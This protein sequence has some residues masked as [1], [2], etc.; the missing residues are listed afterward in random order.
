MYEYLEM[1]RTQEPIYSVTCTSYT[2]CV[3]FTELLMEYMAKK[4]MTGDIQN[5]IIK[6]GL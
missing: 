5:L 1:V 2:N 4:W 3:T 6:Y